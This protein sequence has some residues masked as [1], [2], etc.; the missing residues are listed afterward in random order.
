MEVVTYATLMNS[1]IFTDSLTLLMRKRVKKKVPFRNHRFCRY[2]YTYVIVG[3]S[4][5]TTL[6]SEVPRIRK[7]CTFDSSS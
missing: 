5:T 2:V 3:V 6:I 7:T 1:F 4:Y